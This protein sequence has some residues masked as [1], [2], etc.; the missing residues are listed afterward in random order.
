MYT[1]IKEL[2]QYVSE[3][4]SGCLRELKNKGN[5][6]KVSQSLIGWSLRR[7]FDS[8][9]LSDNSNGFTTV[10]VTRAGRLREWSQGELRLYVHARSGNRQNHVIRIGLFNAF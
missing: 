10:V 6:R 9:S 1:F 4:L 3:S 5:F 7:A 2:P 8:R